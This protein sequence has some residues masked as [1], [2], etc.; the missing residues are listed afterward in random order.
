M[1][2]EPPQAAEEEIARYVAGVGGSAGSLEAL[3]ALLEALPD[4]AGVAYV[5]ITHHPVG[6]ASMLA[7]IL[8]HVSLLPVVEA[9]EGEPLC[10]DRVYVVMPSAGQEW[11]V[12]QGQLRQRA[13]DPG[14]R[15]GGGGAR[16]SVDVFFRA[17]AEQVGAR[18]I[19]IVLSG[20]G[21]DGTL[22]LREIKRCGGMTMVQSPDSAR[23]DGMPSSAIHDGQVDFI[24]DPASMPAS[25]LGYLTARQRS[26][27]G[28]ELAEI[29]EPT[30]ERILRL[31]QQRT[32]HD[33]T[34]YKRSTLLRRLQRRMS[35]HQIEEAEAYATLLQSSPTEVDLL[36]KE[37]LISVTQFFRDPEVW[38]ALAAGPLQELLR[39][40]PS[41]R[42][43]RAWVVGCATGEEA[44]TLGMVVQE[45]VAQMERPVPVQIFA[46]DVDRDALEI[47]RAGRYS[48]GIGEDVPL[49][50]LNR[51]FTLDEEGYQVRKELR[52]LLVFAEHNILH[53]SPFTRIDLITCRNLLIYLSKELQSQ[54]FPLLQYSLVERGLLLLGPSESAG[55]A[56][57]EVDQK[58]RLYR[59][60]DTAHSGRL[61]ALPARSWTAA[62]AL[63]APSS[64]AGGGASGRGPELMRA[65]ER[66]LASQYA[67]PSVL[68]NDRGEVVFVHGSTGRYLEPA[69][70]LVQYRILDM[71][72]HGLRAYLNRVL[73]EANQHEGE[74]VSR[75]ARVHA[76]GE[77]ETVEVVAVRLRMPQ[78]LR[79]LRLVSFIA[80]EEKLQEEAPGGE[81]R[82]L[83]VTE[84]GT[85]DGQRS[86]QQELEA[87]RQ[88]KQITV[89]EL[90]ASNEELQSMN[91]ELQSMNEELQSSN[92]ELEVAKEEVESLNEELRTV[93]TELEAKVSEL[94]EA[95]DDMKNLLDSTDVATLFLGEDLTIKRFTV[96]ARRLVALRPSDVGRPISELATNLEYDRLVEDAEEVLD[97]LTPKEVEVR[98][99]EGY[100]YVLRIMPYRTMQNVIRGLVCTFRDHKKAKDQEA[101]AAYFQEIVQTVPQPLVILD[102][103]L[104]VVSANRSFY[105]L[106]GLE[107]SA[108]EG[109]SF[110]ALNQGAWDDPQLRALLREVLPAERV[111]EGFCL[112]VRLG[113]AEREC[114]L[115]G[116]QLHGE[117]E[118]LGMILLAIEPDPPSDPEK[119][120]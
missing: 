79:G 42:S 68:V 18:A 24:L 101:L 73:S 69:P 107:P 28:E 95:N 93:N 96:A 44:Y 115:N 94:S 102:E 59:R 72:R 52:D 54:F 105:T 3:Q 65:V 70:G 80:H 50:Y 104:D 39:Q 62:G 26:G 81:Q 7:E 49:A 82:Y 86:L 36:F 116:R 78:L 1:S 11:I 6:R 58:A 103:R 109:C 5:V 111:F 83:P 22:G 90:Q 46:S 15:G 37:V 29:A 98:T 64:E 2:S 10:P 97:T 41:G 35:L 9:R 45:C 51:Y 99:R 38:Q 75:L 30:L 117:A 21:S 57:E 33:F 71:A 67:P 91:E 61:P 47:A 48:V 25:L 56:M 43:F 20:T 113:D 63:T 23:F 100:W 92:E 85:E 88:D 12:H 74:R 66:F 4:G 55:D 120:G 60:L 53:D 106:M 76:D 112:R 89:E 119:A 40:V 114:R 77:V 84:I 87:V 13:Q 118:R 17:L 14:T 108:V 19:G 34:G 110:L 27:S 32:G 16:H 8:G 31:V